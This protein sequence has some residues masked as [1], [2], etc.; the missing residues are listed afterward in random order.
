MLAIGTVFLKMFIKIV[1]PFQKI[2]A[3]ASALY[4]MTYFR[5][6]TADNAWLFIT[7][8]LIDN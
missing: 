8:A 2:I 7:I 5:G 6:R 1:D 4:L 3:V